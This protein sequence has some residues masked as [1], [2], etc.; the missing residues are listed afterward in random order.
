MSLLR[1][2]DDESFLGALDDAFSWKA[3]RADLEVPSLS[4]AVEDVGEGAKA[5][6]SGAGKRLMWRCSPSR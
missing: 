4:D 5:C 3:K 1:S 2:C 6:E